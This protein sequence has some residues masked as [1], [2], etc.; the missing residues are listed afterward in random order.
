MGEIPSD[1]VM[2]L[3]QNM[4]PALRVLRAQRLIFW[5]FRRWKATQR[6]G[7]HG[8]GDV[9]HVGVEEHDDYPLVMTNVDIE[10]GY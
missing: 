8:L 2:A 6:R 3:G 1:L 5:C 4:L 9:G 10:N 7:H